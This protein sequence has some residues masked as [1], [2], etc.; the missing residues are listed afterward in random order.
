MPLQ[1]K[2]VRIFCSVPAG[3]MHEV[4]LQCPY[5]R[6]ARRWGFSPV[7]IKG[8][9]SFQDSLHDAGEA[10]GFCRAIKFEVLPSACWVMIQ[11]RGLSC[12]LGTHA[13]QQWC[14]L[15]APNDLNRL[16][17]A[18]S[19]PPAPTRPPACPPVHLFQMVYLSCDF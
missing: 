4:F 14:I 10:A 13:K 12:Y 16:G 19:M 5:R 6:N 8:C 17:P 9:C 7:W 3:G 1:T 2:C 15:V 18:M 11:M